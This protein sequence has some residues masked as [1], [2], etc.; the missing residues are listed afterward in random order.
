MIL[1]TTAALL[2]AASASAQESRLQIGDMAF[3]ALPAQELAQGRCGLFLW[4]R[5]AQ[6]VFVLFASD[7]P[8]QARVR[9]DGRDHELRR[10]AFSGE[11]SHG[12]FERQTFSNGRLTLEADLAFDET[13]PIRDGAIIERGMLRIAAR[14]GAE[15]VAPVGGMTACKS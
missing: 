7:A 9:I 4:A 5:G 3:D 15:T 13:R 14:D 6:P 1:A 8:A 10:T 11:S 2:L 12:H